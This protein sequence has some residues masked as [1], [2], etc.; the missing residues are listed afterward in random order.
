MQDLKRRHH[1]ERHPGERGSLAKEGRRVNLRGG[2]LR[3]EEKQV[4]EDP[5]SQVLISQG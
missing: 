5:R 3:E 2:D 1:R 4:R